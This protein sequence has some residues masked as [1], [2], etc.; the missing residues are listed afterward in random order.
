[1][2]DS[3]HRDKSCTLSLA[4]LPVYVCMWT[5]CI[6]WPITAVNGIF[7]LQRN[8]NK[9]MRAYTSV[10]RQLLSI[11][12]VFDAHTHTVHGGS[13]RT[14]TYWT[15]QGQLNSTT[16][17]AKHSFDIFLH[18]AKDQL[19]FCSSGVK[20]IPLCGWMCAHTIYKRARRRRNDYMQS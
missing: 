12:C 1:M 7:T 4:C 17:T 5:V 14:Y 19:K 10:L 6:I 15:S 8:V 9:M 20:C 18:N 13:V 3:L 16:A 11:S 2:V